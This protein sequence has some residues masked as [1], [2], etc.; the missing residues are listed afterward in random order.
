MSDNI[1]VRAHSGK[2]IVLRVESAYMVVIWSPKYPTREL[3]FINDEETFN[4]LNLYLFNVKVS[5]NLARRF[6]QLQVNFT[7]QS[8]T[9]GCSTQITAIDTS[10]YSR[11]PDGGSTILG[12]LF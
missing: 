7:N 3:H 4:V 2:G 6:C 10:K 5:I 11:H 8:N 1:A 9:I 12:T